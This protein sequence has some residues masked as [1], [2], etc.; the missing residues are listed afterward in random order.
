LS[1]ILPDSSTRPIRALRIAS[2]RCDS[3][4]DAFEL[5]AVASTGFLLAFAIFIA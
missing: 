5:S 4:V 2:M 3:D 1:V